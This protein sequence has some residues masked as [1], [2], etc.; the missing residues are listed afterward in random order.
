MSSAKYPLTNTSGDTAM[1]STVLGWN[2]ARKSHKD[3]VL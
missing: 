2:S 1:G 3:L